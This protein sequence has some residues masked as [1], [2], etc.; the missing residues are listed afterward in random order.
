MAGFP[1]FN[2]RSSANT[3]N[4][5]TFPSAINNIDLWEILYLCAMA[6]LLV[7]S[8]PG[9]WPWTKIIIGSLGPTASTNTKSI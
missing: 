9:A 3:S 1:E 4:R 7:N 8:I 6:S 5:S 2:S